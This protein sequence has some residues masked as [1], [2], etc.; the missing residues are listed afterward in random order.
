VGTAYDIPTL[1][2]AIAQ[3]KLQPEPAEP[4]EWEAQWI[5]VG[6][7]FTFDAQSGYSEYI[8]PDSK[9]FMGAG[10]QIRIENSAMPVKFV[11]SEIRGCDTLWHRI[12][13]R[14]AALHL[15]R[16]TV[17]DAFHA[18]ELLD[19]AWFSSRAS[20]YTD[21]YIGI[22][23]GSL[24]GEVETSNYTQLAG[25]HVLA[26]QFRGEEELLP[27]L[28]GMTLWW[29]RSL[30]GIWMD[31][32]QYVTIGGQSVFETGYTVFDN[33]YF[34]V[35]LRCTNALIN[36]SQFVNIN[37]A[38]PVANSGPSAIFAS[39]ALHGNYNL[40]VRGMGK[41]GD[42]MFD[43]CT[44][45]V[46]A[47]LYNLRFRNV[48]ANRLRTGIYV[49]NAALRYVDIRNSTIIAH[50]YG[51]LK[52]V[53]NIEQ[54]L[55]QHWMVEDNTIIVRDFSNEYPT[56]QFNVANRCGI[57][58]ATFQPA[59]KKSKLSISANE[60]NTEVYA[61]AIRLHGG[62]NLIVEGNAI[63]LLDEGFSDWGVHAV[64]IN[65]SVYRNNTII[66]NEIGQQR[67]VG[68]LFGQGNEY[69][70]N[71]TN[72]LGTG[73]MFV[74][75]CD[76]ALFGANLMGE[77]QVGLDLRQGGSNFTRIGV[78]PNRMNQ[79]LANEEY[80]IAGARHYSSDEL[81]ADASRFDVHTMEGAYWP[82]PLVDPSGVW[83]DQFGTAGSDCQV[84]YP[85]TGDLNMD[86]LS[87]I[88]SLVMQGDTTY[89][90]GDALWGLRYALLWKLTH[91]DSL[92]QSSLAIQDWYDHADQ[93]AITT[94]LHAERLL[95]GDIPGLDST[96]IAALID[97]TDR[98]FSRLGRLGRLDSLL[99]D[100]PQPSWQA[101]KDSLLAI[102]SSDMVIDSLLGLETVTRSDSTATV[103]E[104]LLD[105]VVPSS[106]ME[107][108]WKAVLSLYLA[109]MLDSLEAWDS[110]DRAL[111]L[112]IAGMCIG[113]GGPAT[114]LARSMVQ[115]FDSLHA[116]DEILCMD[117]PEP[118]QTKLQ[119]GGTQGLAIRFI[120]NPFTDMA[121]LD[122]HCTEGRFV[123]YNLF[124]QPVYTREA[125]G[126]SCQM[127][128]T[129]MESLAAGIY[130][131]SFQVKNGDYAT[132]K[133]VRQ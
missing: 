99:M 110:L 6:G 2:E 19:N 16:V 13:V 80:F 21:N 3:G 37:S 11:D 98:Y 69:Y 96:E 46:I 101:E 74:S 93:T 5:F 27:A 17:R 39:G 29:N 86:R 8:M 55:V 63:H 87:P 91:N 108:R 118:I 4:N 30:A 51:I 104:D 115:V 14:N 107:E 9:V 105:A 10:A 88:D 50:Q 22:F 64:S 59:F 109:F 84:P 125:Q 25:F 123:L 7:T 120:P 54:Q 83:F 103:V 130:Y 20:V 129:G 132:G 102:W 62:R 119:V 52:G 133:V 49:H 67:G 34:G 47:D 66:G 35:F 53:F 45:G 68:V 61:S 78:Q 56:G 26:S 131:W 33:V 65:E 24:L 15:E 36:W 31:K 95:T 48:H 121:I 127:I 112:D 41:Q 81:V 122:G 85:L 90:T 18:I 42:L 82:D 92:R 73:F 23:G 126:G 72:N 79:W 106:E 43:L 57:S 71:S 113:D 94:L 32:V 100:H 12:F 117:E 60:F 111:L 38:A 75:N 77:T 124:G 76:N 89:F 58:L 1:S 116:D 128:L 40:E 70:C 114:P 97:R 28:P 44:N